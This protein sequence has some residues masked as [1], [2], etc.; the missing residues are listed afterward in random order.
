MVAR[1]VLSQCG[2][3]SSGMLSTVTACGGAG[4]GM[5][6]IITEEGGVGG[7]MLTVGGQGANSRG[8]SDGGTFSTSDG[9]QQ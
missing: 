5:F 2:G 9:W 4:R 6:S 1:L 8:G 3:V 7:S